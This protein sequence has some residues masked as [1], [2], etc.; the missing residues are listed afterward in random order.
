MKLYILTEEQ[1]REA[2]HLLIVGEINDIIEVLTP[3]ELPSEEEIEQEA[4]YKVSDHTENPYASFKS[5]ANWL[6]Q[7]ILKQNK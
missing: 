5:G 3:I 2:N 6:K 1:I 4:Y 7:Q